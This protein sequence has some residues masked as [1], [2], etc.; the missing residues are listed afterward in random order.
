MAQQHKNQNVERLDD[1]KRIV[2][3][4]AI[5]S[6]L[7]IGLY[8]IATEIDSL[9]IDGHLDAQALTDRRA[10]KR[11]RGGLT[12]SRDD[13]LK[14]RLAR[15]RAAVPEKKPDEPVPGDL[16]RAVSLALEVCAA[17][18]SAP[19]LLDRRALIEQRK[20]DKAAVERGVDVQTR[21]IAD[22]REECKYARVLA[23]RDPVFA[24]HVRRLRAYEAAASIDDE[25]R[26]LMKARD[27]GGFRPWRT[28]LIPVLG[29]R[30]MLVLGSQRDYNS[31]VNQM[32]RRLE[33]AKTL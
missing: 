17:T 27:D 9:N 16:P 29:E 1:D 30:V 20:R 25:L 31:E 21:V 13:L 6:T 22:L 24:L 7:Q 10:E 28:D 19:P 26:D 8:K 4:T 33:E 3:A 2:A 18:R 11:W 14:E 12:S 5:L 15:N 32:Q 23:D